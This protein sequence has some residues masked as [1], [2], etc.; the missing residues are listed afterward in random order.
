M[1][2]LLVI[3]TSAFLMFPL[4]GHAASLKVV[5]FPDGAQVEINGVNTGKVTPMSTTVPDNTVVSVKVQIPNS[6]WAPQVSDVQITTGVNELSVT[7]LP[8]LTQGPPGPV[9]PQG[10]PGIQGPTGP[11]GPEGRQGVP[12][13]IGPQG[14]Q[15]PA[16]PQGLPGVQ[17]PVGPQ[18]PEGP[19]G[20]SGDL[21]LLLARIS[22]LEK[23][24][25]PFA[26][27]SN[28][29]SN[30]VSPI[31]LRQKTAEPGIPVGAQPT[32][33][34]QRPGD[35]KEVWVVNT[36]S[37]S[38]SIIDALTSTVTGTIQG[39]LPYGF[40]RLQRPRAVA[41]NPSGSYAYIGGDGVLAMFSAGAKAPISSRRTGAGGEITSLMVPD[42]AGFVFGISNIRLFSA[43]QTRFFDPN[44]PRPE[45][46]DLG[47][48]AE[49]AAVRKSGPYGEVY[50][51]YAAYNGYLDLYSRNSS[52]YQQRAHVHLTRNASKGVV[53]SAYQAAYVLSESGTI[54]VVGWTGSGYALTKTIDL[55][56][57]SPVR[58]GRFA[59]ALYLSASAGTELLYVVTYD[60]QGEDGLVSVVDPTT[61]TGTVVSTINVGASPAAIAG[62]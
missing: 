20:T 50:H 18:G 36:Q 1:K 49:A 62:P 4:A 44:N 27:V 48:N 25:L 22:Q 61:P 38:I 21:T 9:G 14:L 32:G 16:G 13:P 35:S 8:V 31:N 10:P 37:E 43:D 53:V 40:E 15:G 12:G 39:N 3:V 55:R 24:A 11:P 29:A 19:A 58:I 6:G 41:F 47:F 42:D 5:S 52:Y 34:G 45:V 46:E 56:N 17:G 23:L 28:S 2:K 59:S 33:T 26:Y 54:D 60:G 30:T 57:I 51:V 7:L